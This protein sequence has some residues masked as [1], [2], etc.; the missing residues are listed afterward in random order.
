MLF[1]AVIKCNVIEKKSKN[2]LNNNI[3]L[4]KNMK[5]IKMKTWINLKLLSIIELSYIKNLN[6]NLYSRFEKHVPLP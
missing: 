3:L 1:T 5:I 2:V 4:T 6:H